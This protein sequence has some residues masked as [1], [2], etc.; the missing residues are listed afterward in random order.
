[1]DTIERRGLLPAAL[2][3]GAAVIYMATLYGKERTLSGQY[4]T[5]RVLA[6]RVDIPER[7]VLK[8][9]SIDT[10][11][12]PRKYVA[13]DA[14]EARAPSDVRMIAGL[15]ARVR[16]PKGNQISQ[17]TL[18]PLSPEAGLAMK[19]PPGYRGGLVP[20]DP[21]L[22]SL[23]K[24]GDRVDVLLTFDAVMPDGR[25]QKVTATLLQNVLVIAVGSDL[26]PGTMSG[27]AGSSAAADRA[28]FFAEKPTISVALNPLELEYLALAVQQGN[29]TVGVRGVG[30]E[31]MHPIDLAI[32]NRIIGAPRVP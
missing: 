2:A 3:V 15:V 17:S 27:S 4:E 14:V 19:V 10:I 26:G 22:K 16:I 12:I 13:Q 23:V 11:E 28:A 29:T 9:D 1:M 24:P 31:A 5:V 30:D 25:R 7:T 20:I 6:A 18:V 21:E 32:L 8:E